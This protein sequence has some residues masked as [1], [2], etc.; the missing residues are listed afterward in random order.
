MR[1]KHE[2]DTQNDGDCDNVQKETGLKYTQ[3]IQGD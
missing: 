2:G 1:F 3:G